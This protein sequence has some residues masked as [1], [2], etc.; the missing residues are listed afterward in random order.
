MEILKTAIINFDNKGNYILP[1]S[2]DKVAFG[3]EQCRDTV[4]KCAGDGIC[5]DL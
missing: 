3:C 4:I 5:P 2:C 1:E